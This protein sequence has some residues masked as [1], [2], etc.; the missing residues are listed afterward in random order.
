MPLI[1]QLL[2]FSIELQFSSS[3]AGTV[4]YYFLAVLLSF[5]VYLVLLYRRRIFGKLTILTQLRGSLLRLILSRKTSYFLFLVVLIAIFAWLFFQIPY[6]SPSVWVLQAAIVTGSLPL[7]FASE[8]RES[9]KVL[10]SL[11][12]SVFA[13][14]IF[15]YFLGPTSWSDPAFLVK[16]YLLFASVPLGCL[17][18]VGIVTFFSLQK[19]ENA[20]EKVTVA[21][22]TLMKA[23]FH[24]KRLK[25]I[26]I[27]SLLIGSIAA[28]YLSYAFVD[29]LWYN[30][31]N[32]DQ[33]NDF[34]VL[35]WMRNNLGSND[36]VMALSPLS[37]NMLCGFLTIKIIPIFLAVDEKIGDIWPRSIVMNANQNDTILYGLNLMG[38]K[39]IFV[40]SDDW[41]QIENSN[42]TFS[43][44]IQDFTN[45][46]NSFNSKLYKVPANSSL[47]LPI[48][49]E[50]FTA[51]TG[52]TIELWQNR[53]LLNNLLLQNST[54][55][56]GSNV[57][58]QSKSISL[59]CPFLSVE[60]ITI[61]SLND[62]LTF[63]NVSTANLHILG[64]GLVSSANSFFI[65][66]NTA[67]SGFTSQIKINNSAELSTITLEIINAQG[68]FNLGS[69]EYTFSNASIALT[70]KSPFTISLLAEQPRISVVGS[71]AG[72]MQG[73]FIN[74]NTFFRAISLSDEKITGTMDL[75]I[76]Y[77]SGITFAKIRIES[78]EGS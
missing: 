77:S 32:S 78:L 16:R 60:N 42:S 8:K 4:Y 18:A 11:T 57:T 36:S 5:S 17:A 62:H 1:D 45:T 15:F 38:L 3:R 44:L 56:Q 51:F 76:L 54:F 50:L 2:V 12:A 33:T 13:L 31:K 10:F 14:A 27:I 73:A 34:E 25:S 69:N 35:K 64:K 61:Q 6:P 39:Y 26:M 23:I 40:S 41:S 20:A 28:S 21:G 58:L 22:K 70:A 63:D 47:S 29:K 66:N 53:N 9:L 55:I 37:Y 59:D 72:L 75:D 30:S 7:L 19:S 67:G 48:P 24:K 68:M 65:I 43:S 52:G 46:T 49:P 71:V 74:Q